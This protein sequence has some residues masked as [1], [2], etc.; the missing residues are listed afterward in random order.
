MT[1]ITTSDWSIAPGSFRDYPPSPVLWLTGAV[2]LFC[3]PL[4]CLDWRDTLNVAVPADAVPPLPSWLSYQVPYIYHHLPPMLSYR[5]FLATTPTTTAPT[6]PHHQQHQIIRTVHLLYTYAFRTTSTA[7]ANL[8]TPEAWLVLFALVLLLRMIK[9]VLM[10]RFRQLGVKAG[11]QTHGEAWL[12]HNQERI[13]KF[14]EYVFRLL[15][16]S[17]ISVYGV[18]YFHDKPWWQIF[19][20]YAA[21]K[22]ATLTLFLGF[23]H[24]P[25]D[26]GMTWYYLL[27]AAYNIDALVT[28]LEISFTVR[29]RHVY[30]RHSDGNGRWQSPVVVAWSPS[31]RGDFR[32]MFIH[33]VITNLLVIGSSMCRLTRAGSMIF[34]VHDLSDVPVDLSKLA[35]F[36]KKKWTTLTCFVAM[37]LVWLAT[38]LCILPFVIYA[39]MWTQ[40]Q[41]VTQGIPVLLF[42]YYR[43]IFL[44]LVGLLIGLHITWFGMFLQIFGT[45]LRKN[46]CHDLSEHK[47]GE[48]QQKSAAPAFS[49]GAGSENPAKSSSADNDQRRP[50]VRYDEKKED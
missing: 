28:L 9:S 49:V 43:D 46:E 19:D 3:W 16:H 33:H 1:T 39:A 40:S 22:K 7:L 20:G 34:M 6:Q 10:P 21:T 12:Q 50:T 23:P 44:I 8:A 14:G 15:Y 25:V 18:W 38:R 30:S 47:S 27:Q 5:D 4:G 11:R 32:E 48:E 13:Q 2:D 31:V 29:L 36:L 37:V 17:V 24:Q 41:Y 26:P 45:F 42:L 35:N